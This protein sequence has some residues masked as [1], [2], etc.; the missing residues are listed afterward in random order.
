MQIFHEMVLHTGNKSGIFTEYYCFP[1]VVMQ[2][3]KLVNINY[4]S[5]IIMV[6]VNKMQ[7][8]LVILQATSTV[9]SR[10]KRGH[11]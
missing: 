5:I 9:S 10:V 7:W 2:K 8:W 1:I 3:K 11:S 4:F 6:R